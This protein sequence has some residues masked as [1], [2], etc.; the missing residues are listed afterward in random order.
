MKEVLSKN[1]L[2]KKTALKIT[3][4]VSFVWIIICALLLGPLKGMALDT[5]NTLI[6]ATL[7]ISIVTL[8]FII[9]LLLKKVFTPINNV[10]LHANNMKNG[11]LNS[12]LKFN[13]NSN[14]EIG[15]L[16]KTYHEASILINSNTSDIYNI[17]NRIENGDFNI[18]IKKEYTGD[19]KAIG[20]SLSNIINDLNRTFK[21]LHISSEEIASGAEQVA[22]SSQLLSQ[23][24]SEQ[25]STIEELTE[26]I[27]EI[28]EEIN[29]TAQN[30]ADANNKI[31][32]LSNELDKG[33]IQMKETV[34]TM[35]FIDSKSDEIIKIIK[36]IEDIAFQTNI[37]ALNAAVEAAR[38]GEAGKGFAVVADEVRN[39]AAKSADAAKN[40]NDLLEDTLRAVKGGAYAAENSSKSLT[41]AAKDTNIISESIDNISEKAQKQAE[42]IK[43]ITISI[44]QMVDVIQTNS[45]TAEENS[46]A[47]EELSGQ[48]KTLRDMVSIVKLRKDSTQTTIA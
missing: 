42:S 30:A 15:Q 11:I 46:A 33:I 8:Y 28:S 26:T 47:S 3:T 19:F 37:L 18:D 25:A 13:S 21:T 36:L 1:T 27:K 6:A 16:T 5:K 23:S 7:I 24:S 35:T 44:E 31:K 17:L 48:A 10:L 38:A 12:D 29:V 4:A 22:N 32:I 20:S 34:D 43:Q 2:A 9:Y 39:L 14:D 41:E 45:A 40:T